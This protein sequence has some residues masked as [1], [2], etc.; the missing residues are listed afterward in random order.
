M[1]AFAI[2]KHALARMSQRNIAT[3]DAELIALIGTEVAD[4]YLVRQRDCKEAE[5]DLVRLLQSVRRLAGKRLV[6]RDGQ[7]VTAYR[8]SKAKERRLL[9]RDRD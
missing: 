4:G 2:T 6:V 1:T 8:A 5:Q 7:I 9:R 3:D